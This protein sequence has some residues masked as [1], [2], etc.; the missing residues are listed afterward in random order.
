[1]GVEPEHVLEEDRI[2]AERGIEDADVQAGV[3]RIT[4]EQR[5]REDRRA[6]NHD[7]AGGIDATR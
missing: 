4:S 6:E 7:D 3:R 2:A 1:M 5:D